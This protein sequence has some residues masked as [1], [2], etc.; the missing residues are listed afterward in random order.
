VR[1]SLARIA[2]F[3]SLKDSV[4]V[5]FVHVST[6]YSTRLRWRDTDMA[7]KSRIMTGAVI[8]SEHIEPHQ[9]LEDASEIA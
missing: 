7:F 6:G 9:F 8:N 4:R 5:R 1:Q 2:R 3:E